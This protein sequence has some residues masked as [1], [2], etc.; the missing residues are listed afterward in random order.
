MSIQKVINKWQRKTF[1]NGT[2]KGDWNHFVREVT[3]L[4]S[5][6]ENDNDPSLEMA[7]C[8]ILLFGMAGLK[9]VNL[10]KVVRKKMRIN[11]RRKWGKPDNEGVVSH[12]K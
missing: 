6:L 1:P 7:D 10:M 11:K 4:H 8:V 12:I 9:N 2:I 3:E 5:D